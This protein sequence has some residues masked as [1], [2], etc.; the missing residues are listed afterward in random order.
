VQVFA[1]RFVV[2][3][4][5]PF[6]LAT[7]ARVKLTIVPA[8]AGR[9][10]IALARLCDRLAGLR[11]PMLVPLIDYG[12][13][14]GHWFE[15]HVP[16]PPMRASPADTRRHAL[17]LGRFLRSAGVELPA[18]AVASHAREAIESRSSTSRPIGIHLTDREALDAMRLVFDAHGPP[19][20]AYAVAHGVHGSGLRTFAVQVARAARLSGLL[21]IDR[22]VA[23]QPWS[24]AICRG[25]HLC[26]LDWSVAVED[27]PPHVLSTAAAEMPRR[28]VW[29]RLRRGDPDS[30]SDRS[31]RH[32]LRLERLS[33]ARMIAMIFLDTEL[34]PS[35]DHLRAAAVA[36]DGLPGR[37][38]DTLV[39]AQGAISALYVHETAPQYEVPSERGTHA[40]AGRAYHDAGV[41]RLERVI[42]AAR[43]LARRG[44]HARAQRLLRR[45]SV[46]LAA[47]GA[48]QAAAV[49]ACDLGRLQLDRSQPAAALES[50][51]RAREW[52]TDTATTLRSLAGTGEGLLDEGRLVEAEAVLRAALTGREADPPDVRRLLAETL[53][54]RGDLDTAREIV[55]K[56][57]AGTRMLALASE[58][59]RRRGNLGAAGRLA[60]DALA[61]AA[62]DDCV[63]TCEAR[64]A[65]MQVQAV[66][67]NRVEVERHA[68]TAR[69]AARA[70]RSSGLA[71]RA[72]AESLRCR[73]LCG[74]KVSTMRRDRLL[75]AAGRLPLLRAAQLRVAL[76]GADAE[77]RRI[78]SRIGALSLVDAG[79]RESRAI[80]A[81]ERL[82]DLVHEAT[83]EADALRTI[84]NHLLQTLHACSVTIRS[85][86]PR[87][88]VA[89][90]G[91]PWP[92]DV[93]ISECVLDG[94]AGIVRDGVTLEAAEP[95]RAG[96]RT[97]GCIAVRWVCGAAP[98]AVRLTESLRVAAA[99]I[100]PVLRTFGSSPPQPPGPHADDLLGPGPAAETIR[101]AITRAAMAPY[102]V[103]VEG[104]SGAGKE[105][106]ARAV[107][108]RS[109]RRARRF[110]AINCAALADD[111][112]EAELFGHTR[113][114]FTG[115][116]S[117]RP[118]FFE[119]ADQGTLF[120][121][122]VAEL[123]ARAQAKLLRVLQEGE[124]RRVGENHAR[125]V[126]ARIVAATNRSLQQEVDAG[127]FRAD[128][129]FRLDVIR[130]RVPPLRERPD[131]VPWLATT[132]WA[133]AARRVGTHA[134]L[135]PDLVAA[136][137]RYDW[138][139]NVR[140]L[141]NVIAALSVHAPRRGRVA[142]TLL[143]PHVAGLAGRATT[144]FDEARL[145]FERRFVRAA[146]ARS[147]GRKA[148][149]ACQL[150]V[151][152]QGLAK[153][154]KRLGIA[155]P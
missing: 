129:R 144:S 8:P 112:L 48:T 139:G 55:Q 125:K 65:A 93:A 32:T 136:L 58:I 131:E 117:E 134:T 27:G 37:F 128:L 150:G 44:R 11:H 13:S 121:D 16:M 19:G 47:R 153:M 87:R 63:G 25:R 99:A 104:E 49:A 85:A 35:V 101:E 22:R 122:E 29:L 79:E 140:E 36:A 24:A 71:L 41:R 74:V 96:A 66:L 77:V 60:T 155:D 51:G 154:M 143:P 70:A 86:Q 147:G 95:V 34:G 76:A 124:V 42:E 64:I 69:T 141:Q 126:D 152:R 89:A 5:E 100:G 108:S 28:H 107:H 12:V 30:F 133:D 142:A 61:S 151:S 56:N 130:I 98:A 40:V 132:L 33:V 10:A 38:I 9:R 73:S 113:G 15:A 91:R 123:S 75:T 148:A 46:A 54:V 135:S 92:S 17:H 68:C 50:F 2:D 53:A 14:G 90:A 72:A 84:A 67:K 3:R 26:V 118:G 88:Q 115:A 137:A 81:L 57:P 62:D 21:P 106:V 149:A 59:E 102:P 105:L 45:A 111:L 80:D 7:G 83:D 97:I 94:G 109:L 6:D 138:P 1:D 116:V 18:D 20:I 52:T 23:A 120:L 82:L 43:A 146:L 127:R 110:C 145:E 78:A 114:A 103:L 31:A 4:G 39:G 119:E